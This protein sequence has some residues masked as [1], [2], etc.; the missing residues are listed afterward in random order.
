M[1]YVR[2]PVRAP[3]LS[4]IALRAFVSA[5]ESGPGSLLAAKLTDDSG[6]GI[7]RRTSAGAASP[8]QVPLPFPERIPSQAEAPAAMAERAT[9]AR[10]VASGDKLETIAEFR[11]AYA[12]GRADPISV[13]RRIHRT[14]DEGELKDLG[15]FIARKPSEALAYAEASAERY[16]KKRPLS[17]LDG[18]PVVVK[19]ELDIEGYPTTLGTKF[20]S[21]VATKDAAVVA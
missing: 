10:P 9:C 20:F 12:S 8:I 13:F 16:R 15:Y 11:N 21:T 19:D 4:G 7:F 18:V 5:L 6:L 1:A 17:V 14:L 2:P 3:R